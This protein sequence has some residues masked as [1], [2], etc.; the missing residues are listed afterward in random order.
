LLAGSLVE[1][2][3]EWTQIA[4]RIFSAINEAAS[5]ESAS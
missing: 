4:E 5:G 2:S 3:T 1:S